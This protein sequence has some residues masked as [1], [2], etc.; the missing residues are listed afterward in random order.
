[1]AFGGDESRGVGQETHATAGQ[2][3]GATG[4]LPPVWRSEVLFVILITC[5]RLSHQGQ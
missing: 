1:M 3:A 2:E 4:P 5:P